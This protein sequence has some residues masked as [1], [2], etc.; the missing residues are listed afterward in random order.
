MLAGQVLA[1]YEGANSRFELG[2]PPIDLAPKAAL[3]VSMV[4]HELVTNAAKYGA[5]SDM[6][7]RL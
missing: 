3:A 4:L 7:G 2:G 6:Q 1:S 5:L